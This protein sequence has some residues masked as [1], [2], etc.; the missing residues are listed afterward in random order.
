ML[1]TSLKRRPAESVPGF[2]VTLTA[3]LALV[4][5]FMCIPAA[6]AQV[7]TLNQSFTG[8]TAPGWTLGGSNY[9][10]ILTAAQGIDPAGSGWLRLTSSGNN[11]STYAYDTTSFASANTTITAQFNLAVYN[12]SG[13][14]G[15]TFFLAD[16]SV[17]FSAG[18]YGGSLGY[19]QKTLAGGGGANI[20]GMAGGYL[21]IGVDEYGNYSNPTEGRI[22]GTGFIANAIAVRGPGSGLTGYNY[23]GGT[24]ALGTPLSYPGQSTR[25]TGS[26]AET[27]QMVL[28]STNQLTVSVEFG[29]SGAFSTIF[30]ADL[31]GYTRPNNLIMGFTGST[32]ASTDIHEIQDVVLTSIAANLWTNGHADSS[33]NTASDWYGNPAVVPQVGSDVLLNNAYVSTAQTIAVGSNQ[34]IRSLQIDAPFSYT[35]NGGSLEFNTEGV[36]GTS[37]IIVTQ[38]NGHATQTI[39]SNIQADNSMVVQNNTLATLSLTGTLATNGSPVNFN[40]SGVVNESGQVTGGGMIYQ[41]G[42]GTTTFSSANTY[43]GGTTITAGTLDA[44]NNTALGT[45]AVALGGGTLGS[46]TSSSISNAIALSGNAALSGITSGG[47]LTQTGGSYTLNLANATQSGNVALSNNGTART[48]TAE[49]DS[50]TSTL[51]GVISNGGA[52]AGGLTK[53][54]GGTLVLGSANSY[55]GATTVNGGT[56]QLA[57][58]NA[59]NAASSLTL[60][61]ST[62][63]LNGNSDTVGNLSFNNG[64]ISFGGGTGAFVFNNVASGTG[65]LTI[66]GW[67]GA[68]TSLAAVNAAVA[69]GYLSEIYFAGVGSGAV[70]AAGT[71]TYNGTTA[72]L[73]TPNNTFLTW[74]GGSGTNT[75]ITGGDWTGGTAPSNAGGSTQKLDFLGPGQLAPTMDQSYSANAILFDAAGT[76]S[77]NITQAGKTLTMDGSVPSIIQQSSHN[78][79]ISGG[80]VAF[81]ANGVVDVSGSG[82]LTISSALT[83]SGSI[84]KLSSGTLALSGANSGYSGALAV[85]AGTLAVSGSNSVLGTAGT[86]V[87]SGATLQVNG[88]LTLANALN[89]SGTGLTGAIDSEA[90]AGNTNTLNG[91]VTLAGAATINSGT[92]TL[93]LGGGVTG[94]GNALT[95]TGA[96]NTTVSS[97]IT[98]GTAGVTLN[99]TG[100]TTFS[101]ANTYTGATTANSGT[102]NL[103]GTAVKGDLV[104]N[105]ATVVDNASSQIATTS[106][107]SINSGT[108]NL[109]GKSESVTSFAGNPGGTLAL[110]AGTL[111]DGGTASTS[112]AG[113]ITGTGTF[114]KENTG[115]LTLTGTSSGFTGNVTLNN[116]II[117]ADATNATGTATVAVASSGNFEV[118]GGV[119]LASAFTLSTNGASTGNGAV[120]NISGAN[121]ITGNVTVSANSRIQS[122]AGTLTLT[123]PVGIGAN[124]L[125]VGGNA[126][127]TIN[128]VVSGAGGAVTK[129]GTGTLTLGGVDTY[130]GATTVNG[131]TLQLGVNN[132]IS[133]SSSLS[134]NNSTLSMNGFS[135][136][137][138]TL[139]FNNGVVN[140]G[141]GS[142]A[143]VFS[144]VGTASGL[145]TINNWVSGS[146]VLAATSS[147]ALTSGVLSDIYFAGQGGSTVEAG[148]TTMNNGVLSYVISPGTYLTWDGGSGFSSNW[149]SGSNWTLNTAPVTTA[150]STQKVD[151]TGST[152]LTPT[153]NNS[154]SV[155]SLKFDAA[156]SAFTISLGSKTLT[157]DGNAPS[158]ID[159]SALGTQ[160]LSGGTITYSGNG[161]IDV[162]GTELSVGSVITGS[163]SITKLDS[164][165]LDLSGANTFSGG[166]AITGGTV[167]AST[168]NSAL[169]TGAVSVASGST[170][171]LLTNGLT[172]ANALSLNGD[173]VG[174]NAGALES[175]P[176]SGNTATVSGA[177]TLGGAT[178]I[179]SSSGTLVLSGGV[180]GAGQNLTLTGAGATTVKTTGITT[181]TGSVTLNGTGLTTFQAANTY[182]GATTVNSGTLNLS[183]TTVDGSLTVNG[184][185]VND[186]ASNQIS[187]SS[188]LSVN[189]GTFNLNGFSETVDGI[190]GNPGGTIALGSGTL[191]DNS[192]SYTAYG[193]ALTGTG[194]LSKSGSGELFLGGSS[195]AF[196]GTTTLSGGTIL[197][198]AANAT[199]AT[200][201]TVNVTT[202]TGNFQVEGGVS[203]GSNFGISNTGGGNGAI[204]NV[205][206]N[207]T[208]AGSLTVSGNSRIQSDSGNLTLSGAVG[209]TGNSLNVG[210]SA[211]TT[212]N[213]AI[214]GTSA[215]AL[216]KDGSGTLALGA[217]NSSFSGTVTV[218][219]GTLQTNAVNVFKNTTAITVNTGA[220]MN[221]NG[222]S[223]TIGTISDSGTLAFGSGAANLTLFSGAS[224]LNG[225]LS[226]TGTITL[227]A[228][229][230]LTLG[231]NFSDS[232]LNIVLAGGTLKINGTTDTF[233]SLS[234]TSTSIIDFTNPNSPAASSLTVSGVSVSGG[235]MLNVN[236]WANAIDY[237]YSTSN[238]GAQGTAPIDL[239]NFDGLG[240]ALTHWNSSTGE[241]TPAPEPATYGALFVGLS[242]AGILVYRRRRSS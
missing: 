157:L 229:A 91:A 141:S 223:Q 143:L 115:K 7:T 207:N 106:N 73:I 3:V 20:N 198:D 193:G 189:G 125:N 1:I 42:A 78:E 216:T 160:T 204:E 118:Q 221:L 240:G 65:V 64:A 136:T 52:G 9:T 98:T 133:S 18:A 158:L 107:L 156:A 169:G 22:G 33:W 112:F 39:A 147:T 51:S 230:T 16:A 148:T 168:S 201:S 85:D 76:G 241:I 122:D 167:T 126:N 195:S 102:L 79:T 11:E 62:L 77:F 53:T 203:L 70:E 131:G 97:A 28:S 95:L 219:G 6:W 110:G 202:T 210:G 227:D 135:D 212:I 90:G 55:T 21:G 218:N 45:G 166:L 2:P 186:N 145:L 10:P 146:T 5:L 113:S 213:G 206:G 152:R 61:N 119:S 104:I 234:V 54:G 80:T 172:I 222:N 233:G 205:S 140:F 132:A 46:T 180:M 171:E 217:S 117:A 208:I 37:G 87:V 109:N 194:T 237:L 68:S 123:G 214:S 120:E 238:P 209:L 49:V 165:I 29:N 59:I 81:T 43:S 88:G 178:T 24:G 84:A 175:A 31:S 58:T 184:G 200:G 89:V 8:T 38:T 93:V 13:A 170:L 19:A 27:I 50:G 129:D 75:W 82:S 15:I 14:D 144:T 26:Q 242:L 41:T 105:G 177:V 149:S 114:D 162:T 134:L 150:G 124:T 164:G 108:F 128:G 66:N 151:F 23:L 231:A 154:Y 17:P 191:G 173:G 48:L 99:G 130:T 47:T 192:A 181:G 161:V 34:I 232:G 71:G 226:G 111:T 57:V 116:G 185:T 60:N 153:M 182:T 138:G 235:A 101:G 215:S 155:N 179:N 224:L 40:G 67:T 94:S 92:G 121:S 25:P 199:G 32:G 72:Y 63:N 4:G 35:L 74:T 197:A 127:T 30:T 190:T 174:G 183:G 220:I 83:G 96:G 159:Q 187:T 44:N 103:S 228:G 176:G 56:L 142:Q 196:T 137:V 225:A 36:S 236:N 188:M 12:G 86:T 139:N 100:T 69:A 211:N 163:A 239:I